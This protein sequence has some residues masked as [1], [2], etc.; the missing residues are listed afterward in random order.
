MDH[1]MHGDARVRSCAQGSLPR[2]VET[3]WTKQ[4]LLLKLDVTYSPILI[5]SLP[6]FRTTDKHILA[7]LHLTSPCAF[8]KSVAPG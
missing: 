6:H 1:V 7:A 8:K 2:L 4:G 3:F 5:L